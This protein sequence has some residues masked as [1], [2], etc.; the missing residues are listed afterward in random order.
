MN[1]RTIGGIE[2]RFDT[3]HGNS[4]VSH[5]CANVTNTDDPSMPVH[6]LSIVVI[7][8]DTGDRNQPVLSHEA[9]QRDC[10]VSRGTT[11]YFS[12]MMYCRAYVFHHGV[13]VLW[14][15]DC[16]EYIYQGTSRLT[17]IVV[18]VTTRT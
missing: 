15:R 8:G 1:S 17:Q 7:I 12:R 14:K 18:L 4:P 6:I 2:G 11:F 10:L 9:S 13:P 3:E 5:A 16:H